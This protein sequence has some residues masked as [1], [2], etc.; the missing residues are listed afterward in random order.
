VSN[1]QNSDVSL[2][3][4]GGG[5]KG[6]ASD[7]TE[8]VARIE[9]SSSSPGATESRRSELGIIDKFFSLLKK[10]Q[11]VPV[12]TEDD[13]VAVNIVV[14]SGAPVHGPVNL[15]RPFDARR[16]T[17]NR[18]PM[19]VYRQDNRG[20]EE[21]VNAGGFQPR[22]LELDTLE[23]HM[24]KSRN[25]KYVSTSDVRLKGGSYGVYEYKIKLVAGQGIDTGAYLRT[26]FGAMIK[27]K[28]RITEFS[29]PGAISP[30]Q[31]VG[32]RKW[33]K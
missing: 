5:G 25:Y 27:K 32:V 33:S 30:M 28:A 18:D 31:I 22:E 21:V 12:V 26:V 17:M 8:L 15:K 20:I 11:P 29:I 6:V 24:L 4:M 7:F 9:Q 13:F 3:M 10:T 14:N 1:T 23:E 19:I 2:S 16:W